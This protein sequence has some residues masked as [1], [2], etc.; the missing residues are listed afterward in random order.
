MSVSQWATRISGLRD[1]VQS[2][3]TELSSGLGLGQAVAD[4]DEELRLARLQVEEHSQRIQH[5]D[6]RLESLQHEHEGIQAERDS[7]RV[8]L[9]QLRGD[10][11]RLQTEQERARQEQQRTLE[12]LASIRD[13][14]GGLSPSEIVGL[15]DERQSVGDENQQLRDQLQNLQTELS[16]RHGLDQIVADREEELRL[17]RL[18]VEALSRQVEQ[19]DD[20]L[21]GVQVER[22]PAR[23]ATCRECAGSGVLAGPQR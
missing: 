20:G 21:K 14:L 3:R 13:A 2:L 1:Q 5:F 17:A 7:L 19:L 22:R 11:D 8:Q 12:E 18:Q 6:G 10:H 15:R 16:S 23:Q 4:R 9:E